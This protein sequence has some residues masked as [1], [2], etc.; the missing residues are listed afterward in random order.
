M[1]VADLGEWGR[2]RKKRSSLHGETERR[3]KRVNF[4]S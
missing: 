4:P 3:K 1:S 2:G